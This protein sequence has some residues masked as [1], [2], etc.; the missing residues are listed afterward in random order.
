MKHFFV[1]FV[2]FLV[3]P[4]SVVSI[5]SYFRLVGRVYPHT[6]LS[7]IDVSGRSESSLRQL[8][9]EAKAGT[10]RVKIRDRLYP[11]SYVKNGVIIDEN[12][13]VRAVLE[14][15]N[16][17]FPRN[18]LAWLAA[19]RSQ[20]FVMPVYLFTQDFYRFAG[21]TRFDFTGRGEVITVDNVNKSL[22]YSH[23]LD[24]VTVDPESLKSAILFHFSDIDPV[25]VPRLAAVPVLT[26][27]ASVIAENKRLGDMFGRSL[28][29]VINENNTLRK[30]TVTGSELKAIVGLSYGQDKD[31]VTFYPHEKELNDLVMTK[32]R[33]YLDGERSTDTKAIASAVYDAVVSRYGGLPGTVVEAKVTV[34]GPLTHGEV[35][36][37]YL[38]IDISEQTMY[39]FDRGKLVATHKISSGLYYPTPR[40]HFNIINKALDAYSDIYNVWMPYWMAFYFDPGLNAYFG[41]HELPYWYTDNGEKKQR[42]REFIG[43]PHTGG[44][45]SL[46]IGAAQSIYDFAFVGMDVVIHD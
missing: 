19:H 16:L 31:L 32:L 12:A 36:A 17:P 46:D 22:D 6:Y 11:L 29:I 9:R 21:E 35:A 33:P 26:H 5:V 3:I 30:T 7:R 13:T 39:A 15:N 8:I 28:D 4:V 25:I 38:E 37:R 24:V 43:S 20:A 23:D 41:I 14:V 10:F 40:G 42:P 18:V 34:G 45:V 1:A 27:E 44:C 2:F